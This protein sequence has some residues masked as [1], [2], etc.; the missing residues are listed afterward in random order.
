MS[1]VN[2]L[3]MEYIDV[4]FNA[5]EYA[6]FGAMCISSRCAVYRCYGCSVELVLFYIWWMGCVC[7][8]VAVKDLILVM[9]QI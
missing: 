5:V 9:F 1:C 7:V 2:I 6:L 4:A 3:C 8:C